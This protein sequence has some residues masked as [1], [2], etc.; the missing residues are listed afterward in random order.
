MAAKRCSQNARIAYMITIERPWSFG[1]FGIRQ[2]PPQQPCPPAAGTRAARASRPTPDALTIVAKY[3][4]G[5]S[6][7]DAARWLE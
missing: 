2:P 1:G 5:K 3:T 7:G 4:S 6:A